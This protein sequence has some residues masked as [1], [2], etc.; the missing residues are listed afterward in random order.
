MVVVVVV[1]A[2]I[3][4]IAAVAAAAVVAAVVAAAAVVVVQYQNNVLQCHTMS[5]KKHY[6]TFDSYQDQKLTNLSAK[7]F[8]YEDIQFLTL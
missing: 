4:V 2:V 6:G 7:I 3:V 5:D 8:L 1:A